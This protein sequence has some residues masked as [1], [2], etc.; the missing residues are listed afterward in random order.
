MG[1]RWRRA[2]VAL[3]GACAL[4]WLMSRTGPPGWLAAD[5]GPERNVVEAL[6]WLA[7]IAAFLL[8][9]AQLVSA[10]MRSRRVDVTATEPSLDTLADQLA[11]VVAEQWRS[12][13][14]ERRLREPL[15]IRWQPSKH[16]V[17]GPYEAATTRRDRLFR[18]EP[19]PGLS[20]V[21]NSRLRSGA[22]RALH[23]VYG[24]L[25]S[26]RLV[27]T[28]G[29]GAG[30]TAAAILLLLDALDFR[31]K[32]TCDEDR[33]SIPVPVMFTLQGWNPDTTKLK[34]WLTT[35]LASIPMFS[36]PNGAHAA[37]RLLEGRRIAVF[38]DG[39][40][41]ISKD[42]RPMVLRALSTEATFRLVLLTRIEELAEVAQENHQLIGAVAL[43]IQPI[44]PEVAAGYLLRSVI[45]PPPEEWVDLT[46]TLRTDRCG[47]LAQALGSP[48][49]ISLV[50]DAYAPGEPVNELG[51]AARFPTREDVE[52]HLLD[53]AVD[54]AYRTLAGQR[55]PRYSADF[56]REALGYLAHRLNTEGARDLAWWHIPRWTPGVVRLPLGGLLIACMTSLVV[57]LGLAVIILSFG[58]EL[59]EYPEVAPLGM[60]VGF[61]MGF[62]LGLAGSI[63][64]E[65]SRLRVSWRR[66]F[67]T[68]ED[69][70]RRFSATLVGGFLG[71][72]LAGLGLG[73]V[74]GLLLQDMM[75]ALSVGL[76]VG[77][78]LGGGM[79]VGNAVAELLQEPSVGSTSSTKPLQAWRQ[80]L[81]AM[82]VLGL[83]AGFVSALVTASG[84]GLLF[85]ADVK[86]A[87][88]LTIAVLWGIGQMFVGLSRTEAWPL[89]LSQIIMH[90]TRR[91]VPW[92]LLHFLEDAR[93]RQLLRTVGPVYQFRHAKLQ[94][95]M[96]QEYAAQKTAGV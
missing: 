21:S 71:V 91:P 43:E 3:A 6:G 10:W 16:R 51:D 23:A 33:R 81:I 7:G 65:P 75:T 42:L 11:K 82:P 64:G 35:K 77:A 57:M 22:R 54:A 96:A 60:V 48:L 83:V 94:D 37:A 28:G 90:I 74:V 80:D 24:G 76:A 45:A 49:L 87:P 46:R 67:R 13:A 62:I 92:R 66:L 73:V 18:F 38:L 52:K 14:G 36:G 44:E 27:I 31:E 69:V 86:V 9:V 34:E 89:C 41:E 59:S 5:K 2:A 8:L 4:G 29:P 68:D 72:F 70:W 84:V 63:P 30:K 56:A 93:E 85:E 53:R 47:P 26:G 40:D 58:G 78:V 55:R 32:A 1:V 15:P 61:P 25:A 17:A 12:E 19:L 95:R 88:A 79:G 50:R 20:P 39:L